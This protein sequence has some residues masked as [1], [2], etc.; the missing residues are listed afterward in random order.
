VRES[1]EGPSERVKVEKEAAKPNESL[2]NRSQAKT[3]LRPCRRGER[4]C[5]LVVPVNFKR[6]PANQEP[7]PGKVTEKAALY[8][9]THQ[10]L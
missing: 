5:G 7:S 6:G 8:R 10:C 2:A 3:S 4:A 9:A 1:L